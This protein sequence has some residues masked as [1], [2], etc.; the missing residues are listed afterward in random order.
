M[1]S[2]EIREASAIIASVSSISSAE[3]ALTSGVTEIL[4]IE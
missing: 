4:I 2:G 1:T 3:T